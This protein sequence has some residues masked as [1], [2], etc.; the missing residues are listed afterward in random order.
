MKFKLSEDTMTTIQIIFGTQAQEIKEILANSRLQSN[1][2]IVQ[3]SIG[4]LIFT[5]MI[6]H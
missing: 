4:W 3:F 6:C 5:L 2:Q 1:T